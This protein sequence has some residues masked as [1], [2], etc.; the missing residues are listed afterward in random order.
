MEKILETKTT[1]KKLSWQNKK[2]KLNL[3][4]LEKIAVEISTQK[5]YDELMQVYEAGGWR[6]ASRDLPTSYNYLTESKEKVY[7]DSG[8]SFF[9]NLKE[10]FEYHEEELYK[11]KNFLIISTEKFYEM[12]GIIKEDLTNL[13]EYFE[14]N[15]PNRASKGG[16]KINR[17]LK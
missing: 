6:W 16:I 9:R 3:T 11:F 13:N 17:K 7:I 5:D 4:P 1:D 8:I 12:Q 2:P 10:Y 14:K 15:S